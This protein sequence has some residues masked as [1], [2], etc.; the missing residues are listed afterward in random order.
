MYM[1]LYLKRIMCYFGL[2]KWKYEGRHLD[3]PNPDTWTSNKRYCE[4]CVNKQE[5]YHD[6]YDGAYWENY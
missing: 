1:R 2:H 5:L 6:I 3:K 4:R